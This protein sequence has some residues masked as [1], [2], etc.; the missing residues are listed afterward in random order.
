MVKIGFKDLDEI[1]EIQNNDL[2]VIESRPAMGKTNFV[3]NIM[4]N[5]NKDIPVLM[6]SLEES[7]EL[8]T[9]KILNI[10]KISNDFTN[11]QNI[12]VD[13]VPKP[14]VDEI[15]LKA[16]EYK[17]E[18]DIKLVVIDYIQLIKE[19]G[20][21]KEKV[22]QKL[23]L[24][25]NEINVPIIVTSQLSRVVEEREN[26]IPTL[27]DI[28]KTLIEKSDKV[29]LI[30]RDECY[31][32]DTYKPHIAE[33]IIAKNDGR[34]GIVQLLY[35]KKYNRFAN[36]ARIDALSENKVSDE[37]YMTINLSEKSKPQVAT[38]WYINNDIVRF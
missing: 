35:M 3:I 4:V 13:D 30:Y 23:K 37:K 25:A 2:I 10:K 5:M 17:E 29:L 14:T 26:C 16:K 34:T 15:I 6:F 20:S 8:I 32:P 12:F 22:V 24:L 18:K 21:E 31:N 1:I 28:N 19:Y 36:I 11:I 33:I 27:T 9:N 7:R 38:F